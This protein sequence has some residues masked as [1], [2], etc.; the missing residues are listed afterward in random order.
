[1][2]EQVR[3]IYENYM[4]V[5]EHVRETDL[6]IQSDEN[7]DKR[8]GSDNNEISEEELW[9]FISGLPENTDVTVIT[10]VNNAG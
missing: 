5:R 1:M 7:M 10:A 8:G 9:A 2:I 6:I 3:N 4:R